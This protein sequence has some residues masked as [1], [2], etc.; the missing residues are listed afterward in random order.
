M[1]GDIQMAIKDLDDKWRVPS[2]TQEM[3]TE[4]EEDEARHE[5]TH[6]EEVG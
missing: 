4:R 1:E 3:S 2:L 6:S 5:H